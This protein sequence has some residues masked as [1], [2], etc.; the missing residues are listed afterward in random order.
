MIKTLSPHYIDVP[1]V[2]PLT[3]LTCT[4]F[5][6]K[7]YIWSGLKTDVPAEESFVITINNPEQLTSNRKIN[8]ANLVN[9]KID[10]L[11]QDLS[12]NTLNDGL[13]Q[14]W[15]KRD[16]Y[17]NTTDEAEAMFP[18]LQSIDIAV[19]GYGYGMDGE[20]PNTPTNKVLMQ[21][22]EFKVS[23]DTNFTIPI[24]LE[25]SV[26]PPP[27][28]A[29]ITIT[30]ITINGDGDYVVTFEYVGTYSNFAFIESQGANSEIALS[31]VTAS[32]QTITATYTGSGVTMIIEGYDS[33]TETYVTSNTYNIT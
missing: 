21:G 25:Q 19:K 2:S 11:Q 8:I 13:N 28:T 14:V 22:R 10:F 31:F 32:P 4:Y 33:V 5:V 15:V 7:L 29:S 3:S 9:S 23:R 17:Y 26:I 27:P 24:E 18:Q 30:D 6:L 20:N 16:V 12:G 1:Y